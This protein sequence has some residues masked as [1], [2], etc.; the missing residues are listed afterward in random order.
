[1]VE[2]VDEDAKDDANAAE[3]KKLGEKNEAAD[4]GFD[5]DEEDEVSFVDKLDWEMDENMEVNTDS[6]DVAAVKL[7]EAEKFSDTSEWMAASCMV[8]A[9]LWEKLQGDESPFVM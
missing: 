1:V 7:D 5:D 6:G 4:G 9:K 8:W 3:E 2:E